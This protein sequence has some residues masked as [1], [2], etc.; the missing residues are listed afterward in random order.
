MQTFGTLGQ[1][2]WARGNIR[3]RFDIIMDSN[4][5]KFF[6]F[7]FGNA[8]FNISLVFLVLITEKFF[9]RGSI[10]ESSHLRKNESECRYSLFSENINFCV[11]LKTCFSKL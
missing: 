4:N 7:C 3:D 1:F 11:G 9:I 6:N 2:F 10:W 8:F 5:H